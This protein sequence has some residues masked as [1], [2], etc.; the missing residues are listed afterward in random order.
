MGE[1]VSFEKAR[2][3][4]IFSMFDSA[5]PPLPEETNR[6]VVETATLSVGD[7]KQKNPASFRAACL[8]IATVSLC[9]VAALSFVGKSDA[10]RSVDGSLERTLDTDAQ[11][12]NS[13]F[14]SSIV[15]TDEFTLDHLNAV[16]DTNWRDSR[17][18]WLAHIA[19][20]E[21]HP[22]Y[23]QVAREKRLFSLTHPDQ[24]E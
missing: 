6:E 1:V 13:A 5:C 10:E 23:Q 18:T 7:G 22:Y 19:A 8:M 17:E 24:P 2:Q 12:G 4:D 20:M 14:S 21:G 11:P 16:A 3:T 9:G 15:V